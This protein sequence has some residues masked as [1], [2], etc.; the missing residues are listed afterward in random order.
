MKLTWGLKII[1]RWSIDSICGHTNWVFAP[2]WISSCKFNMKSVSSST[3]PKKKQS[4]K[5]RICICKRASMFTTPNRKYVCVTQTNWHVIAI[6][7]YSIKWLSPFHVA[8]LALQ[9]CAIDC[10]AALRIIHWPWRK[11]FAFILLVWTQRLR[12]RESFTVEYGSIRDIHT[13]YEYYNVLLATPSIYSAQKINN[14][15]IFSIVNIV[16]RKTKSIENCATENWVSES[17]KIL[18]TKSKKKYIDSHLDQ[19]VSNAI[20]E[21]SIENIQVNVFESTSEKIQTKRNKIINNGIKE[22]KN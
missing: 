17:V 16:L 3:R 10:V 18:T 22:M 7:T 13:L 20:Q 1:H 8:V 19:V 11:Q 15:S 4:S 12:I 9:S 5:L 21:K 6:H 14:I 2:S